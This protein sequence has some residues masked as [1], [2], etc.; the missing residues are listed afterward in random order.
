MTRKS[1]QIL[2]A[3]LLASGLVHISGLLNNWEYDFYVGLM[4]IVTSGLPLT[5]DFFTNN[6][7]F[8]TK[9]YL[10]VEKQKIKWWRLMEIIGIAA[11]I[12]L[13]INN[14]GELDSILITFIIYFSLM[15]LLDFRQ[16]LEITDKYI[17]DSGMKIT[18]DSM[19]HM[20]FRQNQI[21]IK[22]SNDIIGEQRINLETLDADDRELVKKKLVDAAAANKMQLQ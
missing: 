20:D 4:L 3:I 2:N 15:V 6:M 10:I 11:M 13:L 18:F 5:I 21:I 19:Q 17:S 16:T 14:S 8:S 9:N 22:I 7:S 12:F 1:G